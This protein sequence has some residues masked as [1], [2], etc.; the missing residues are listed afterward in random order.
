[1]DESTYRAIL[2]AC[3]YE[4]VYTDREHI[5]R[6][7]NKAAERR[8]K[9]R[10]EVGQSIFS[11]HNES[12][13]R[14]IEDFLARADEGAG[15]MFEGFNKR[16]MEREFFTPVRAE[17]GTVIGYFERHEVCFSPEHPEIPVGNYWERT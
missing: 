8:Y 13:R 2:D 11:C 16:T 12:S 7:M 4:I 14:K 17:D 15:E 9:G 1:M 3:P 5:V 10:L 6:W